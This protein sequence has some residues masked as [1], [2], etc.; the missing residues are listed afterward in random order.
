MDI[1][2]EY[3]VLPWYRK[4]K[5]AINPTTI[6]KGGKKRVIYESDR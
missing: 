5:N 1:G 6:W 2:G 4:R 3:M